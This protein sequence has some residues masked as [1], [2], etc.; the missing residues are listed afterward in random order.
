MNGDPLANSGKCE[1][2]DPRNRKVAV[3]L[4]AF[5]N[6]AA[7]H[8]IDKHVCNG[9][10]P[11]SHALT[12]EF[13]SDLRSTESTKRSE[14]QIDRFKTLLLE[15][16]F[17]ACRRPQAMTHDEYGENPMTYEGRDIVGT[18]CCVLVCHCGLI[19]I[20]RT[21]N[22]NPRIHTA[23]FKSGT[24][25]VAA[26]RS[27]LSSDFWKRPVRRILENHVIAERE[28]GRLAHP[29]PESQCEVETEEA[30]RIVY[31]RNIQFHSKLNWGF[32][33]DKGVFRPTGKFPE[34]HVRTRKEPAQ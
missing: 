28:T 18:P 24:M 1:V 13:V 31:R 9:N 30:R 19:I 5:K 6:G 21:I 29:T 16:T 4:L 7:G 33:D 12:E 20:I 3:W 10:E 14:T 8:I 34:W 2:P 27:G 15:L 11:W 17:E 25:D 26:A 22:T 23:F 32:Q